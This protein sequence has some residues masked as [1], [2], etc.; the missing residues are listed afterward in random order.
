MVYLL[1]DATQEFD[2]QR[3]V[4]LVARVALPGSRLKEQVASDKL[5]Y[6]TCHAPDIHRCA[7]FGAQYCLHA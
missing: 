5:K 3:K 2:E 1:W 4:V 7:V 6:H